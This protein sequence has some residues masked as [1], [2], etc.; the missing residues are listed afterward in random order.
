MRDIRP[1]TEICTHCFKAPASWGASRGKADCSGGRRR[2]NGVYILLVREPEMRRVCVGAWFRFSEPWKLTFEI[3]RFVVEL[4][5]WIFE[6]ILLSSKAGQISALG[7]QKLLWVRC[8]NV[9]RRASNWHRHWGYSPHMLHIEIAVSR[10]SLE[11]WAYSVNRKPCLITVDSDDALQLQ[12][13]FKFELKFFKLVARDT[14]SNL[15][16]PFSKPRREQ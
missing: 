5:L 7:T 8:R 12:D 1:A 4:A 10:S 13:S 6:W 3:D 11:G 15:K 9:P 16:I 2:R 14:V